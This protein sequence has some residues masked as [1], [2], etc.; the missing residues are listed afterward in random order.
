MVDS[1]SIE[2]RAH[3]RSELNSHG[4]QLGSDG[5]VEWKLDA[6]R[7]PRNWNVK[8]KTFDVGLICFFELWMSV[9]SSSGVRCP[10]SLL[11]QVVA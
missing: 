7:H 8:R 10:S 4:L 9:L 3:I 1:L 2:K 5:F 6:K 11:A